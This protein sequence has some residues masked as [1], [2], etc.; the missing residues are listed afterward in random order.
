MGRIKQHRI[1]DLS[2]IGAGGYVAFIADEQGGADHLNFRL[3]SDVGS[4]ALADYRESLIDCVTYGPQ[5]AGVSMGRCP[6]GGLTNV[7]MSIRTPGTANFCPAPPPTAPPPVLVNLLPIDASWRYLQGGNLDGVNWQAPAF[8][9]SAW[10]SGQAL[11][12]AGGATPEPVRTPL[13]SSSAN[14]TYY[15]RSSFNVP[16]NFTATSLQFSNLIDDGAVFY[17]NGREVARYNMPAA[18]CSIRRPFAGLRRAAFLDWSHRGVADQL[19]TGECEY[20]RCR[21]A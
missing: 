21:S 5:R 8:D 9:D 4:I 7:T 10:P 14:V 18:P 11:L 20:H 3:T 16:A 13:V 6:D 17:V 19:G 1:A 2:F 12:G 15:F